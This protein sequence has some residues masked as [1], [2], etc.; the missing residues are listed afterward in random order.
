MFDILRLASAILANEE[1]IS[2]SYR[3]FSD[4]Y[5]AVSCSFSVDKVCSRKSS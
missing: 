1:L 2:S 4:E 3:L 5:C